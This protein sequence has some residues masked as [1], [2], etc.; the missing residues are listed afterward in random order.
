MP[1]P[2]KSCGKQYAKTRFGA[3]NGALL[4]Q[5]HEGQSVKCIRF[6]AIEIVSPTP[7]A[8]LS[9]S[10]I[11]YHLVV[12]IHFFSTLVQSVNT[13]SVFFL[14]LFILLTLLKL[15]EHGT[16]PVFGVWLCLLH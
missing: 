7:L 8:P 6:M 11:L 1:S 2:R 15:D 3:Y 14:L 9:Y 12:S 16:K 10:M 5:T 4:E 13:L